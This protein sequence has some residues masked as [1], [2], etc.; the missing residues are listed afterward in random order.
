MFLIRNFLAIFVLVSGCENPE[1]APHTRTLE[2][3]RSVHL[4]SAPT[5]RLRR[6]VQDYAGPPTEFDRFPARIIVSELPQNHIV[7][8]YVE[9]SSRCGSGG[10]ALL[11]LNDMGS[12]YEVIGSVIR[13]HRPVR[14]LEEA[15]NGHPIFGVWVQGGGILPG[16]EQAIAFDGQRYPHVPEDE[17]S[18]RAA[19]DARGTVLIAREDV[20]VLLY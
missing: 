7:L 9:K 2:A 5:D 13:V 20:G 11:I 4:L 17:L 3:A 8:V 12:S 15:R 1:T 10:C 16:F 18:W 19:S 14:L 6:F